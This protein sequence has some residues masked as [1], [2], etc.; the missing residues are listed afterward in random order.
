[1][2]FDFPLFSMSGSSSWPSPLTSTAIV[3]APMDDENHPRKMV[4]N[5]FLRRGAPVSSTQGSRYRFYCGMPARDTEIPS[6]P[7]GFFDKVEA[8]D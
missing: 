2:S 1:M 7:F 4:L 8:Y 6:E 3:S 5:A